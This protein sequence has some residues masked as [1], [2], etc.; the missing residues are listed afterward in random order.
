[1]PRMIRLT[2]FARLAGRR[3]NSSR[4]TSSL[5][6]RRA[7]NVAALGLAPQGCIRSSYADPSEWETATIRGVLDRRVAG[8][9]K[10]QTQTIAVGVEGMTAISAQRR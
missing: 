5:E 6:N 10:G 2:A 1:M 4:M 7:R 3:Q 9:W 8:W